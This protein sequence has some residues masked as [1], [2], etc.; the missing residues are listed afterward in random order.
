MKKNVPM[1]TM[2]EP[3]TPLGIYTRYE[4]VLEKVMTTKDSSNLYIV[5]SRTLDL[6]PVQSE[7]LL[8]T[9]EQVIDRWPEELV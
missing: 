4:G 3:L 1:T 7:M 8:Y 5:A 2:N 6:V 9:E